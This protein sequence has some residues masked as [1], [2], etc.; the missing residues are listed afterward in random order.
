M[1]S[2]YNI[3][4]STD[5]GSKTFKQKIKYRG[6]TIIFKD[7]WSLIPM[8]IKDFAQNF[9]L[10]EG[11]KEMYPYNYYTIERLK[12]N[13]GIISEAGKG[14]I[15]YN[16]DQ[17]QFEKN[18]SNLELYLN[19]DGSPSQIKTNYFNMSEYVKFY[20]DQDVKILSEG[21][22]KFKNDCLNELG[23]NVDEVLTISSLAKK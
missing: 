19:E 14:E 5:K 18:I 20:C 1:F 16:W 2:K 17:E 23:I 13:I 11:Q 9:D 8:K 22:D 3:I 15:S 6:K 10:Q 4:S 12:T 7:S 21:F